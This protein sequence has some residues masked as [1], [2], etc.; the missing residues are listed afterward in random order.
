M[1][2]GHLH[3]NI[4]CPAQMTFSIAHCSYAKFAVFFL[5]QNY[6]SIKYETTR[7]KSTENDQ[8]KASRLTLCPLFKDLDCIL[9]AQLT[10][11]LCW[12]ELLRKNHVYEVTF[13]SRI[14]YMKQR[15][16]KYLENS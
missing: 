4:E 3:L 15:T 1:S 2:N 10:S 5:G 14:H 11:V 9:A 16:F 6:E 8:K 12:D 13:F 7:G